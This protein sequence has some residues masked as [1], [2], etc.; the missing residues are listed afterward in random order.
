MRAP[1]GAVGPGDSNADGVV[2]LADVV[3][4]RDFLFAG[5]AEPACP[6]AANVLGFDL[7][8]AANL[9]STLS[10]AFSGTGVLG[11]GPECALADQSEDVCAGELELAP[12]ERGVE[13]R[14]LTED[15]AVQGWSFGVE[16][17]GCPIVGASTANTAGALEIDGGYRRGGYEHTELKDGRVVTAVLLDGFARKG[18]PKGDHLVLSLEYGECCTVRVVDGITGRGRPVPAVVVIDGRAVL[19]RLGSFDACP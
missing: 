8:E 3:G 4:H 14:G 1:S 17:E 16:A 13:L 19:P 11:D 15:D 9:W 7:A 18:L 5:G 12:T 6:E 2:D 10:Y